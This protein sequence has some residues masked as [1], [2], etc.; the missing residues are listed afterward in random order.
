[1]SALWAL[2]AHARMPSRVGK[3]APCCS[4][5]RLAKRCAP[6]ADSP[7]PKP[8]QNKH[9]PR[10]WWIL[11]RLKVQLKHADGT[12]IRADITSSEWQ[13]GRGAGKGGTRRAAITQRAA[14][15]RA[16]PCTTTCTAASGGSN[17]RCTHQRPRTCTC[18]HCGCALWICAL[19]MC[20]C[21]HYGCAER[22]L[23]EA[24]AREV[25]KTPLRLKN[26]VVPMSLIAIPRMPPGHHLHAQH[27]QHADGA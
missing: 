9:Y 4:L 19:W 6:C 13:E 20:A 26:G 22:K 17:P 11:G 8:S 18:A 15:T 2:C 3:Q 5:V 25:P 14:T 12:Y 24:L 16:R 7:P 10:T 21:A 23:L 1:M 27:G